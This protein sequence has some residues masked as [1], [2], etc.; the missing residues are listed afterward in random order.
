MNR[1][2]RN[3]LL[4]IVGTGFLALA[5]LKHT[6]QGYR[7]P[8]PFALDDAERCIGYDANVVEG[9]LAAL[10]PYTGEAEPF[11]GRDVLELGPGAD[12]G[13]AGLLLAHGATSY[14]AADANPL[15]AA[16]PPGFYEPLR[17]RIAA[18]PGSPEPAG[19][20]AEL[21]RAHAG[22]GER[23]RW[24]CRADFDLEAML[25]PASADVVVSQAA[26]EHFDDVPRTLVQLA[27]VAR[28]GAV[29]VAEIDLMTHSRG[30]RER[31]PLNLYRHPDW[32]YRLFR[33]RG[34]PNR[35]R[36]R[37]HEAALLAAGWTD[38][39]IVRKGELSEA[40]LA[41]VRDH[42]Q[43]RW[44]GDDADMRSLSIVVLARRAN[45]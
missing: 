32:L 18:M 31:D 37:D 5:W 35:M 20:L 24:S 33:F 19:V 41:E 43:P 21:E 34:I 26:F 23:V 3:W 36:P 6:L 38:V 44:R 14:R 27:R 13:V 15:L 10:R 25:P 9:W 1:M 16:P 30:I 17:R 39:R 29:L 22:A 2:L 12:L 7:T 45:T 8:R 40:A 28:P 4:R 42:L 11:R